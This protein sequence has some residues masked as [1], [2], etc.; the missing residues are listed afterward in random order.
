MKIPDTAKYYSNTRGTKIQITELG[1]IIAL[2][3]KDLQKAAKLSDIFTNKK[4]H[5]LIFLEKS[6]PNHPN[7]IVF[8]A[9][10]FKC[11]KNGLNKYLNL[12][13]HAANDYTQQIFK[14]PIV[15]YNVYYLAIIFYYQNK[16]K[17]QV[18]NDYS[19]TLLKIASPTLS[20]DTSSFFIKII[21]KIREWYL[22]ESKNLT[23]EPSSKKMEM[24]FNGVFSDLGLDADGLFPISDNAIEWTEYDK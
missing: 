15:R 21:S 13:T 20:E 24:F 14:K 9:N 19:S 8:I 2:C 1:Q 6:I 18:R 10:L 17:Y 3:K 16:S 12:P 5:D 4:N 22:S 7:D 23:I 11:I